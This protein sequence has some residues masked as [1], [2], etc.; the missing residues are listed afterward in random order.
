MT[1]LKFRF[2]FPKRGKRRAARRA[3]DPADVFKAFVH[4][5]TQMHARGAGALAAPRAKA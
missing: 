1:H 2:P 4:V 5:L 3:D